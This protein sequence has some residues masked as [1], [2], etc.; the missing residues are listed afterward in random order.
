MG[1]ILASPFIQ[2]Q[3]IVIRSSEEIA[4]TLDADGKL[5]GLLFMPEMACYCGSNAIVHR[6]VD[7]TCVEGFGG[8]RRMFST[9][10]L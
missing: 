3:V 5:E 1:P 10:L 6:N 9:V 8:M 2:G 4:A 7:K